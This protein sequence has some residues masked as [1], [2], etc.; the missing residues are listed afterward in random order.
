MLDIFLY[1]T[2]LQSLSY[3]LARFQ[4]LA[5]C[6]FRGGGRGGG[7]GGGGAVGLDPPQKSQNI[8]FL[9]NMGPDPL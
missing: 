8:G 3:Q 4:L 9:G 5:M 6:G 1:Y 7:G 2:P